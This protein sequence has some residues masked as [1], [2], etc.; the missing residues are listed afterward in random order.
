MGPLIGLPF[1][2]MKEIHMLTF[3]RVMIIK[4]TSG[5][6]HLLRTEESFSISTSVLKLVS[7]Q[8]VPCANKSLNFLNTIHS[9]G[10]SPRSLA[11]VG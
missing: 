11:Y 7:I 3:M 10:N 8:F 9:M 2:I 5:V 6:Q 1:R 4:S